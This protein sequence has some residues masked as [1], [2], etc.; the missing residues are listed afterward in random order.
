MDPPSCLNENLYVFILAHYEALLKMAGSILLFALQR[1][2][3]AACPRQV[4][5]IE[6]LSTDPKVKIK[7]TL[8][9]FD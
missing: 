6:Q 3:G 1:R 9:G 2:R 5:L 7:Q 4:G 8:Y